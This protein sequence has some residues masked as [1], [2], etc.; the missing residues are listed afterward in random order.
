MTPSLREGVTRNWPI[1]LTA[2]A[3]SG[4]LWAVVAAEEPTT[5]IVPVDVQISLPKGRALAR[6]LPQVQALYSGSA[7]ELFKLYGQHPTIRMEVPDTVSGSTYL[8]E[9]STASLVTP[10]E[11]EVTAVEVQPR[12]IAIVLD[13]A[14]E[15]TVPVVSRVIVTPDSGFALVGAPRLIPDSVRVRGPAARVREIRAVATEPLN[16]S[17]TRDP[18]ETTVAVDTQGLGVVRVFPSELVVV[19]QIDHV[20]DRLLVGVPVQVRA[21]RAGTWIAEPAVVV[22]TVHGLMRRLADLTRDSVTAWV[23]ISGA[24]RQEVGHVEVDA[25]NDLSAWATPDTV[26]VR[27]QGG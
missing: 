26:T 27:R 9:L 7:R 14:V 21:D 25:P 16:L 10:K 18:M 5:E 22:V 20:T 11:A 6:S 23:A 15:R 2:L 17:E 1:K 13:D 3:L 19:V 4:V 8:L 24:T 12:A